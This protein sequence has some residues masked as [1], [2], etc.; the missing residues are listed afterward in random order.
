M[1]LHNELLT[2]ELDVV[3][4]EI[5][6]KIG[7]YKYM[8]LICL[9]VSLSCCIM[10][11]QENVLS[12]AKSNQLQQRDAIIAEKTEQIKILEEFNINLSKNK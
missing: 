10:Y 2:K 7:F 8:T 3:Q 4:A 12:K 6:S 5:T 9:I 11:N 1:N